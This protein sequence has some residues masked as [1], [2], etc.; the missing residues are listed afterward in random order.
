MAKSDKMGPE[1]QKFLLQV[2]AQLR[3]EIVH[4]NVAA[5]K[6]ESAVR[7]NRG[8]G[9]VVRELKLFRDWLLSLAAAYPKIGLSMYSLFGKWKTLPTKYRFYY[10]V[11]PWEGDLPWE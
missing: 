4:L 11:M 6:L 3:R 9:E 5:Q 1:T 8:N 7:A 2:L 10:E